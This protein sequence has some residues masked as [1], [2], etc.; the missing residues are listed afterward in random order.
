MLS[1]NGTYFQVQYA[2]KLFDKKKGNKVFKFLRRSTTVIAVV[3]EKTEVKM[4]DREVL[5]KGEAFCS[6]KDNFSR[7]KGRKLAT[8]RCVA[9][10]NWDEQTRKA[11]WGEYVNKFKKEE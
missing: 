11:F 4:E 5:S 1:F 9:G 8:A 3:D 7:A 10:L 2:V 6:L